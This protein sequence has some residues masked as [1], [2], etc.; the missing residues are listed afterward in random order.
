MFKC[1]LHSYFFSI[2]L[3]RVWWKGQL[4]VSF[5]ITSRL[6][7]IAFVSLLLFEV[8]TYQQFGLIWGDNF[9]SDIALYHIHI[10]TET[11]THTHKHSL[12]DFRL[13]ESVSENRVVREIPFRRDQLW[14]DGVWLRVSRHHC[15]V[16]T[17]ANAIH[18]FRQKGA[19]RLRVFHQL[20]SNSLYRNSSQSPPAT[21]PSP[22]T[23][24]PAL[25]SP[26][27]LLVFF[28]GSGI[29]NS[30]LESICINSLSLSLPWLH[31]HVAL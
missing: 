8:N 11:D 22:S 15:A 13:Y 14:K 7:R 30:I 27:R 9:R 5:L 12:L 18:T 6:Q 20:S 26:N 1:Q 23:F 29:R 17:R 21:S 25:H 10:Q 31:S 28:Q 2:W 19:L 24:L 3:V 16:N 4:F